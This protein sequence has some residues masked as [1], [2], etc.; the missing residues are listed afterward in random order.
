VHLLLMVMAMELALVYS[1]TARMARVT[2]PG[3]S[4]WPL[5]VSLH[6]IRSPTGRAL[7]GLK[8]RLLCLV[9]L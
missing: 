6:A 1:S 9:A 4:G 2:V 5:P 3:M 7:R 8:L